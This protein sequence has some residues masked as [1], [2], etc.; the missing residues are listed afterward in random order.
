MMQEMR[1]KATHHCCSAVCD[2]CLNTALCLV[3]FPL[4]HLLRVSHFPTSATGFDG[5]QALGVQLLQLSQK[6]RQL[7]NGEPLPLSQQSYLSWLGFT[8]EGQSVKI[9]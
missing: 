5:V 6:K 3:I 2:P 9:L 4:L 1:V 8:A 7:I